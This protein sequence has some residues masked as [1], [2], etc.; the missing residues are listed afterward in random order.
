MTTGRGSFFLKRSL[1][2]RRWLAAAAAASAA[3]LG[4]SSARSSPSSRPIEIP[5]CE[6]IEERLETDDE[7]YEDTLSGRDCDAADMAVRNVSGESGD[8]GD[9]DVGVIVVGEVVMG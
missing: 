1:A 6:R 8:V 5:N 3:A 4:S 9:G 2:V 7:L